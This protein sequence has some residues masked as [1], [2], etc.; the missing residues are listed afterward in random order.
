MGEG[1]TPTRSK[2]PSGNLKTRIEELRGH[3]GIYTGRFG[4]VVLTGDSRHSRCC[5]AR[6]HVRVHG[7]GKLRAEKPT[8]HH[9]SVRIGGNDDEVTSSQPYARF[10]RRSETTFQK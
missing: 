6:S 4:G 7:R 8:T 5:G 1:R 9:L 3:V 2:N 10:L